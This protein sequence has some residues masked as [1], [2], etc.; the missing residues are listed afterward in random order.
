MSLI[1]R[2]EQ[3]YS[4]KVSSSSK[5]NLPRAWLL[6]Q[7]LGMIY[8]QRRCKKR[9]LN[10]HFSIRGAYFWKKE[11]RSLILIGFGQG[12]YA[13]LSFTRQQYYEI[14]CMRGEGCN[15]VLRLTQQLPVRGFIEE[16]VV[17]TLVFWDLCKTFIY[18]NK[19]FF[20][21]NPMKWGQWKKI[22]K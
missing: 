1:W 11:V 18:R 2:I 4:C 20:S 12:Y 19:T 22:Y 17:C 13:R 10:L 7:K 5:F 14:M 8:L 9:H 15:W 6:C 3:L 21:M 16:K